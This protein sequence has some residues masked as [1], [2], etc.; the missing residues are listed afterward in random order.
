[1]IK[2]GSPESLVERAGVILPAYYKR[3]AM[4]IVDKKKGGATLRIT[5]FEEAHPLV[6]QRLAGW[7]HKALEICGAKS[8]HAQ[9]AASLCAGA[10]HTDIVCT[11]R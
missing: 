1:M 10:D 8:C 5:D 9:I 6:E 4:E 3:C 7:I 11:W 2:V